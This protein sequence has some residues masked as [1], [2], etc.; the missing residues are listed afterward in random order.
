[1]NESTLLTVTGAELRHKTIDRSQRARFI[2]LRGITAGTAIWSLLL[3]I[4]LLCPTF[5][6]LALFPNSEHSQ[7][8]TL[9]IV[10]FPLVALLLHVLLGP[11]LEEVIYRGL[12]LQLAR[13]YM[14]ATMAIILSAAVFALTHFPRGIGTI[15]V[16]F[17]M[18]CLFA[19]M[20]T[21]SGS[22]FPGFLCHAVFNYAAYFLISP[23]FGISDKVMA[24]APNAKMP[25]TGLFPAWWIVLSV[26]MAITSLVL[27]RREF[28]RR[29]ADH[30]A[31]SPRRI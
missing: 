30:G 22:L 31:A 1:M 24:L 7:R 11:L 29:G 21:R 9:E 10:Q 17:A 20:V 25:L 6:F 19:W 15:L 13:R 5:L 4:A 8:H 2:P 14:P 26:V 18:G 16:A 3:G 27:L 23:M 28:A 12:F